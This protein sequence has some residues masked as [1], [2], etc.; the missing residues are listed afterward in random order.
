[1]AGVDGLAAAAALF[2]VAVLVHN[3]DHVRRGVDSVDLEGR[4]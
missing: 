4:R 1:M 3:A 2:T